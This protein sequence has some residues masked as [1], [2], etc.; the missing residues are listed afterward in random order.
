M[1]TRI[2][3]AAVFLIAAY[4]KLAAPQEFVTSI[5][6]YKVFGTLPSRWIAVFIPVLECVVAILLLS[7]LWVK[8]ALLLTVGLFLA[9]DAMILQA[10]I[11]GLDIS[12][13]CFSQNSESPIDF[14]KMLENL[15]YTG[16]SMGAL[17]L[18]IRLQKIK[19]PEFMDM[20]R[21]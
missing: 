14:W 19:K 20:D 3:L 1:L 4:P 17:F 18:Y 13:G 6:N 8:E 10:W 7:G 12:C 9:F 16:L 15:V 21:N 2:A 5:E 11:R